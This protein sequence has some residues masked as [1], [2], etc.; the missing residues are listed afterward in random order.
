MPDLILYSLFAFLAG[1]TLN[2]MPCVLPVMPFKIQALL[3]EIKSDLRSRILAAA[4]LLAGSLGVF[5]TLGIATVYLGLIWGELFQSPVFQGALSLFLLFAAVATFADWSVRLPQF[6][7]RIPAQKYMGAVLTGAL[8][9]ILSTPCS[10]PFLGSVLAY[11]VTQPPAGALVLFL[12]IGL[13]LAF[14]YVI[15]MT[16]PG[17]LNRLRFSGPWTVQLKHVL[18]FILLAGATFFSRSLLP[19]MAHAPAWSLLNAAIIIW[20]IV[21][22]ITTRSWSQ[23]IVPVVALGAV[24]IIIV[25]TAGLQSTRYELHWQSFSEAGLKQARVDARPVMIEFT[26]DWCLNCKV[27]ERT[28]F[29]SPKVV[30]AVRKTGMLP[31]RVD[32]TEVS[33]KN[34]ALLTSYNGYAIPYIVLLDRKGVVSQR[35]TGM[36]KARTLVDAIIKAGNSS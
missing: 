15:L 17:L 32:I 28:V 21:L 1:I 8:A 27:L 13:G 7:Y 19:E 16:W 5:L 35:F 10:G 29:K 14:P 22:I 31:L 2:L 20:A 6:I 24:V 11:S 12:S 23:R 34:N 26:A 36:F 30:T 3:R 25:V 9:G 33:E 4:A 18:G